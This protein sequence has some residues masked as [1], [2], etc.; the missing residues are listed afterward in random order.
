MSFFRPA[1]AK[2]LKAVKFC[3]AAVARAK[4]EVTVKTRARV[5]PSAVGLFGSFS[6]YRFAKIFRQS[7]VYPDRQ[8]AAN[9]R[10]GEL[11]KPFVLNGVPRIKIIP[12]LRDGDE[13]FAVEISAGS[14]RTAGG[15]VIRFQRVQIKRHLVA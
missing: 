15:D 12:L 3:F 7:F 4:N 9:D 11:V 14:F 2:S 1:A 13:L 8:L 10:F 5:Y 6:Q